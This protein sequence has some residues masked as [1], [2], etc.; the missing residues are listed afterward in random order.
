MQ[1]RVPKT[2]VIINLVSDLFRE[3]KLILESGNLAFCS[4]APKLFFVTPKGL[5]HT[6]VRSQEIQG[7]NDPTEIVPRQAED[8]RSKNFHPQQVNSRSDYLYSNQHKHLPRLYSA[9]DIWVSCRFDLFPSPETR[10]F[11]LTHKAFHL[12]ILADR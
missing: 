3:W 12:A 11:F 8:L 1:L 6:Q 5:A 2:L 9:V 7:T 4:H 10:T